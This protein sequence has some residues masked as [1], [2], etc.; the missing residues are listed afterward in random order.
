MSKARLVMANDKIALK[1]AIRAA[2]VEAIEAVGWNTV[3]GM[4]WF[5]SNDPSF[6]S[7]KLKKAA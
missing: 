1:A 7:T 6:Q 3:K 2:V 5:G 4:S